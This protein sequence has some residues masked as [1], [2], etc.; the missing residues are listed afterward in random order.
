MANVGTEVI[1]IVEP[2]AEIAYSGKALGNVDWSRFGDPDVSAENR[3][4]LLDVLNPTKY[5]LQIVQMKPEFTDLSAMS[6]EELEETYLTDGLFIDRPGI[7]LGLNPADCNA[8]TM[9]DAARGSILGLIHGGRQGIEGQIHLAALEKLTDTGVDKEDVRVH[10][11]PSVRKE[12][13]YYPEQEM[14][15]EQLADPRWRK[16]LELREGNYHIDLLGRTIQELT[17]AGIEPDQMQ[18][19]PID[20]GADSGYFSHVRRSRTGEENGRNG[21]AAML[22]VSELSE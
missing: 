8:I 14:S 9:Y 19:S 21:V 13:Y 18:V 12:S 6:D 2:Y 1:H 7:A 5:V 11:A 15:A 10:F 22:R 16:F 3:Q 20:V 17:D 4:R